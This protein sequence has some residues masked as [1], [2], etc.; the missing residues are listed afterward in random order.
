MLAV[1]GI[2]QLPVRQARSGDPDAWD[3]LFRR[4]QLPIYAYVQEL[5]RD[6]Q[7]SLD[8]VQEAFINA[9]R[10]I[11]SLRD[12]S[13][14][15]S[16]LF[17]I[18]R[19]KVLQHWRRFRPTAPF[20]ETM[21]LEPGPEADAPDEA[22]IR[23]EDESLFLAELQALPVPQRDVL[24]LHFLEGFSLAEIGAIT[25]VPEGTVKSRVHHAKRA[26]RARIRR[27]AE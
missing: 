21:E 18:A 11:A 19:Q 2:E 14:F 20:E 10:H 22:L 8:I 5:V 13:K 9:T 27:K 4:Y 26:L 25:G 24:L 1:A 7:A 12:D 23:R 3:A 16:W 17:G 6:E 15:G